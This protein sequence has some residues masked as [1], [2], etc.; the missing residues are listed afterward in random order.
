MGEGRVKVRTV[1]SLVSLSR[2]IVQD[3]PKLVKAI[4]EC[5]R[6]N[7]NME[8]KLV[9]RGFEVQSLRISTNSFEDYM[10]IDN[11]EKFA[12]DLDLI[13]TTVSQ[14]GATFFNFGPA[15]SET[16]LLRIPSLLESMDL[17]FANC[18]LLPSQSLDKI[19]LVWMGKVAAC[20]SKLADGGSNNFRFCAF[21]N[22]GHGIPFFPVS[23]HESGSPPSFSI[24]LENAQLVR[25]IFSHTRS[26]D[27]S[28][29]I[30]TCSHALTLELDTV[31]FEISYCSIF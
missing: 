17:A 25:E 16:G 8:A 15:R 2:E 5:V 11:E 29:L 9:E 26:G 14:C 22:A 13:K 20:C 31:S 21:A 28:T 10:T 12:Q 1:T 19:D 6:N 7:R 18:D 30:Q 24:A 27:A 23:Y 3:K 4:E